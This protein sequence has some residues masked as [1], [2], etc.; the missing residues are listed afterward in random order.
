[1]RYLASRESG[2]GGTGGP[3]M[4]PIPPTPYRPPPPPLPSAM[5][6]PPPSIAQ[7]GA[8]SPQSV[9]MN[10]KDLVAKKCS[11]RGILFAPVPN[12]F[13]EIN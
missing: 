9:P 6:P 2:G 4:Q 8:Y 11:E 12:R 5:P 13:G 1:M 10:F 3:P 7:M